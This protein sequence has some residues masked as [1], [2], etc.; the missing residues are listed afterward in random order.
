MLVQDL[1]LLNTEDF[2]G[3]SDDPGRPDYARPAYHD[4]AP[5]WQLVHDIRGGT[6]SIR[7]KKM[8]YLP[9]FEAETV[10]DWESR[11]EMTF[12]ADHYATT[13]VEHVGLVMAQPPKIGDDVPQKIR[14]LIE[15]FD[16]AGNHIDVFTAEAL[17]EALH[18]GHVVLFT[19]HP[20][21]V[22][23]AT[24]EDDRLAQR[25]PYVTMYRASDV[26]SW[27]AS[28]V[29]GVQTLTQIVFREH[30]HVLDGDFGIKE[31]TR[32][33]EIKQEV[34]YDI[35]SG[36][37]TG[38][39]AITWRAW[40]QD[41]AQSAAVL[42]VGTADSGATFTPAG[43]GTIIGPKRIC[44]R[45]V[46]GGQKLG[47]LHSLPH[48]I[49][50]AFSNVEETQVASDY[51]SIMHKANVPTPVFIGRNQDPT[52][53]G[54]TVQMGQGIDI[55][56]GGDAKFLE[57]SG[58]ALGA[59]RQR[60]EDIR[61]QMRRQ[62]ASSGDESGKV[63]T[64]IEAKIY[65]KQRNAKLSR[66]ARS[67][68]DALEGVFE[69]MAAFMGLPDGGSLVMNQD[70]SGDGIDPVYLGVLVQAYVAGA[71]PLDALLYALEKGKLPDD[72]SASDSA[73][74]LIAE[75]MAKQDAAEAEAKRL[76]ENP[77][78]VMPPPDLNAPALPSAPHDTI[79]TQTTE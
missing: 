45:V 72:F 79:Q 55:P 71:M 48:L 59:T 73:L 74:Q 26:M 49:G 60:I 24:L 7:R 8:F 11:V 19:D 30:D 27:R 4:M 17:S 28:V 76:A 78:K 58:K 57:P 18:L 77:P 64:A 12:V 70:Y 68:Q 52:G 61:T 65:A 23:G 51:A 10:A 46:Y 50:L 56:I 33:R 2:G 42:A 13:L 43:E 34:F 62:G 53:A 15:D 3:T 66:A 39:G 25:R 6:I 41:N 9:R 35:I 14:D 75:E 67:M 32:F 29:G 31:V 63:M 69:D 22:A 37:A 36:R 47:L 40:T 16:G 44:A 38:L 21:A 54:T 20:V 5:R 1:L